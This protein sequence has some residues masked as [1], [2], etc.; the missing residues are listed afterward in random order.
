MI[1]SA[2]KINSDFVYP[3]PYRLVK[4][5][6]IER[7][8]RF[9]VR[10][11]LNG[12]I[13]EGHLPDPGRLKELLLPGV[14]ILVRKAE[15]PKRK[16]K[17]SVAMVYQEKTLVSINSLLPNTFMLN[18]LKAGQVPELEAAELIKPE[19]SLGK[20]RYDFL[21][22]R[23]GKKCLIEVKGV[24]LIEDGIA[25][26]P[27]A[28]TERGRSHVQHLTELR[29]EEYDTMVIFIVQRGDARQ[30]QP[31]WQRDPKFAEALLKA[32]GAGVE[33]KVLSLTLTEE[34][35]SWGSMLPYNF[36]NS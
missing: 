2:V 6:F 21:I 9:I 1:S 12:K 22:N 24:S 14:T 25:K 30:F 20:H 18:A 17:W 11:K 3:L 19:I 34:K 31:H 35:V 16:T 8:N 15:G 23:R 28:V 27:D 13:E 10:F 36:V 7:P 5:E 33:I 32:S 4:A 26:F 29:G